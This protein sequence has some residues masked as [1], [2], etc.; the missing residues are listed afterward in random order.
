MNPVPLRVM[1]APVPVD[2]WPAAPARSVNPVVLALVVA[3]QDIEE[4]RSRGKVG[5]P[6]ATR[7][8]AA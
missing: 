4:R 3:L 8:P 1:G 5:L 6:P 2:R 7:R